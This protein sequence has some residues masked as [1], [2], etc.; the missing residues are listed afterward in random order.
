MNATDKLNIFG[1]CISC[2]K[3]FTYNSEGWQIKKGAYEVVV[4][5]EDA[6]ILC[7]VGHNGIIIDSLRYPESNVTTRIIEKFVASVIFKYEEGNKAAEHWAR[8]IVLLAVDGERESLIAVSDD[9]TSEYADYGDTGSVYDNDRE[10]F[11]SDG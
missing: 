7:F 6:R 9:D 5:F 10:D 4:M 1:S 3:L 2:E 11:H 8:Q